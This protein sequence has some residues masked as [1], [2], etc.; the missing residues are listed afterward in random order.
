M[1]PTPARIIVVKATII[2]SF[3][4]ILLLGLRAEEPKDLYHQR[5]I[6]VAGLGKYMEQP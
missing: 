2:H 4:L 6:I 5:P 1:Q 3:T